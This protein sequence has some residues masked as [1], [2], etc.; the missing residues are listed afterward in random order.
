MEKIRHFVRWMMIAD[1]DP[2]LA[3]AQ[4]QELKTQIPA[5]YGLLMVNAVAVAYTHFDAAPAYLTIGILAAILAVTILRFGAW[6]AARNVVLT[7]DEAIGKL[8][9]TIA[10]AFVL[11]VVYIYW[12]LSLDA[13][14]G[15]AQRGHVALFI[16]ITSIGCIFCLM[17]LPQAAVMVMAVVT[18]PYL[19]HYMG[20]GEDVY[21]AM[22][23]NIML[24]CIVVLQVLFNSY[25]GFR[26][27]ITSQ[28]DLAAKQ[29]ETERLNVENERLARTD[30]LTGLPNRRFFFDRLEA[31]ISDHRNSNSI[32][33]VGILDMDR[34]KPIN[35]TFGH[36]LGDQLLAEAGARLTALESRDMVVCRLGGDEFGF[37]YKGNQEGAVEVGE[38]ICR[39]ISEPYRFG[40]LHLSVG[41]SCGI[42]MY[43]DAGS[44]AHDLFDRS[45]Y[46]LYNSKASLRGS[47]TVYSASHEARIRSERAIEAALQSADLDKEFEV[48]FQPIVYLP[49]H[50]IVGFEALARWTSPHLETVGP[51]QF[52]PAAERTGVIHQ[53]TLTLFEKA[54]QQIRAIPEDLGLSF[55]LSAQDTTSADT[56]LM[57]LDLI[58]R[59]EV[60]PRL[61][62]FDLREASVAG[63][64]HDMSNGLQTLS[65]AGVS[66][67]WDD[68]GTGG[69]S[70]TRLHGLPIDCVK[71]DRGFVSMICDP[72]SSGIV[73]SVIDLSR[74]MNLKCIAE[75]VEEKAQLDFLLE[76]RCL[77]A[78]G[79]HFSPALPFE[80]VSRSIM[81]SGTLVGLPLNGAVLTRDV[82]LH[83][84]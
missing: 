20:Q 50:V 55:N 24:V 14:G 79:D 82:R 36:Q 32:F 56:V 68:F 76:N 75:G 29:K 51:D 78:Q 53:L 65:N 9:Q 63:G 73:K 60:D 43:P 49:D 34:F 66:L 35:D 13:Y 47:T 46:A 71:I 67:A 17:H 7:A 10:L 42:A 61:I 12:S 33:A 16:A 70:L 27:L 30:M 58:R 15:P 80:D 41:A 3:L 21:I 38:T 81:T 22:A 52:I 62:T 31:L 77:F 26:N 23:I 54:L 25:Y 74:S 40:D 69:S 1:P 2:D 64:C 57:L 5:L 6:L 18:L 4:Y 8:R 45:D 39:R 28:A 84:V 59:Y 37:L 48:H 11:S 72:A 19:F 83:S 44:T